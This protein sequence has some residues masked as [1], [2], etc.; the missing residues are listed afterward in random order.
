MKERFD[1]AGNS[2]VHGHFVC[3]KNQ[4]RAL[5][6]L[7]RALTSACAAQPVP[8]TS[9]TGLLPAGT[10]RSRPAPSGLKSRSTSSALWTSG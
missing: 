3:N 7:C 2:R 1:Q 6:E 4:T 5:L 10:N 8:S 9:S